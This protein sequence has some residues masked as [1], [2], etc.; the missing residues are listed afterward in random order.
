M[1]KLAH[2]PTCCS[3]PESSN[4]PSSNEP[5]SVPSPFLCHRNPATTQSQSRSCLTLSITRLSDSYAPEIG[6]AI[7]PSSPAPSKR[8]NQ[9][10]ATLD[11]WV[12]G[13]RWIG[14]DADE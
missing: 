1:V 6:L 2:T 12:T 10:E 13:V 8:R 5:T 14:G 4:S 3:A 7:T 9:S 11:S